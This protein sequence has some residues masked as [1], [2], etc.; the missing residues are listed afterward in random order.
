MVDKFWARISLPLIELSANFSIS[1]RSVLGV[2]RGAEKE[3]ARVVAS[4]LRRC[5]Y[6]YSE[7][8]V[9]A[10]SALIDRDLW[11]IDRI[12]ELG[13]E[14]FVKKII[15]R[16]SGS[17]LQF[18]W[19]TMYLTFAWIS[20]SAAVLDVAREYRENNR[21]MLTIWCRDY[22]KE[23]EGYIDTLDLLL[24]DDVYEDLIE[25]GMTRG[26]IDGV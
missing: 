24:N 19:Y 18:T 25:L 13:L 5:G 1:G 12:S 15:N 14:E 6:T 23:V 8:L 22:A 7:D 4:M 16:A 2:L 10:L 20:A 3:L 17:F 9:Y 11:I 26:R 21:D